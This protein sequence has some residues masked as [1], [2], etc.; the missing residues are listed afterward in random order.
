MRPIEDIKSNP[1]LE[2]QLWTGD[3]MM[4]SIRISSKVKLNVV[5]GMDEG[6]FE[7]VSVSSFN[8]GYMP[9]WDDMCKVKDIFWD[10]EEEC[11]QIHP[12]RSQYV[13]IATNCL[14]IWRHKTIALPG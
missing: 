8:R 1:A 3:M 14:H 12:K 11:Y 4:G 7:H 13:N 2:S 6:G 10:E 5:C 9:S